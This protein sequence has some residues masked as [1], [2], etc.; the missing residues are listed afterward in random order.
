MAHPDDR[1]GND[2]TAQDTRLD[3]DHEVRSAD[4]QT[5][6]PA[7]TASASRTPARTTE[8][9]RSE[10]LETRE[11]H[12]TQDSFVGV[13]RGPRT[14]NASWGAIFAGTVTFLAVLL[15]FGVISAALGLSE[16]DGAAVGIWSVV[17]ILLSLAAGGFVAGALAVRAGLLHG[18]VTWAT[19]LVGVTLLI[20]W[21]GAGVLG[22]AGGALGQA[23]E[24]ADVDPAVLQEEAGEVEDDAA[25]VA[26]EAQETAEDVQDDAA[27]GAWW[28]AA[29]LIIGAAV[30]A[31]AGVAG[32]RT[33]HTRET[34]VHA[35]T[36]RR[37]TR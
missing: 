6:P 37:T 30:A 5:P 13:D 16:V 19:S 36:A 4:R 25:D 27:A 24:A 10:R 11:D 8:R 12:P 28:T 21:L 1:H 20:G 29:G 23:A 17:A 33:A 26:D 22:A 15:V 32:A 18:L 2:E 34:E 31:F 3:R 14:P 9:D 7:G 35:D